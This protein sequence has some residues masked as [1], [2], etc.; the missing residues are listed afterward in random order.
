ML[1]NISDSAKYPAREL[2]AK[3]SQEPPLDLPRN[4]QRS[5]STYANS[6]PEP[7]VDS[8]PDYLSAHA[9]LPGPVNNDRPLCEP[10]TYEH[11]A[12][13]TPK[14]TLPLHSTRET[15]QPRQP[16]AP[17]PGKGKEREREARR[18]SV[19]DPLSGLTPL[20]RTVLLKIM[21]GTTLGSESSLD[22]MQLAV[23]LK[24]DNGTEDAA[25]IT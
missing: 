19:E 20:Q 6:T 24:T 8:R 7:A 2:V 13:A 23:S 15:S 12:Q 10:S 11:V 14:P 18:L 4:P 22:V 5:S 9:S 17:Q 3:T 21:E 25:A 16:S 1:R